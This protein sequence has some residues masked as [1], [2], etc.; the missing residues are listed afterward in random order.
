[1]PLVI[2]WPVLALLVTAGRAALKGFDKKLSSVPVRFRGGLSFRSVEHEA[3][4]DSM[5][6]PC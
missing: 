4:A 6:L 2:V 1:M 5:G 3:S